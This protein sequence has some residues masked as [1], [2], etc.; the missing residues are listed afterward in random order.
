MIFK[1]VLKGW[2]TEAQMK[3]SGLENHGTGCSRLA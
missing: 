3:S 1:N 2:E